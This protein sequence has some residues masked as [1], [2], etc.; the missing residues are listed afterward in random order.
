MVVAAEHAGRGVELPHGHTGSSYFHDLLTRAVASFPEVF[1]G[2]TLPLQP[3]TFKQRYADALASFEAARITSDQRVEIARFVCR[4]ASRELRFVGQGRDVLFDEHMREAADPLPLLR[5]DLPGPGKLVPYLGFEGHIYRGRELLG[6][7]QTL[8]DKH[9][10]TRPAQRALQ[11]VVEHAEREGGLSLQGQRFVLLGAAAELAPTDM[12]LEAGADV[13]WIDLREPSVDRLLD[14]RLG[15]SLS[16]VKGGADLL[17]CPHAVAATVQAFAEAGPVHLCMYAYAPGEAQEWRLTASMNAI[18]RAL[19]RE[20]VA[21]ISMLVS[22]TTPSPVSPDDV[23]VAEAR[24]QN[25]T[26][27]RRTLERTGQLSSGFVAQDSVHVARAVVPVQGVSYQAA[28][29]IGKIL[30]AECYATYGNRFDV[31]AAAPLTV[32]ANVAPITATRSLAHPLFEAAFL[33]APMFDIL[34][35][36]PHTTR[37]LSGMLTLHDLLNPDAPG[38]ADKARETQPAARA[39]QIFSQQIH[40]G[41][42]AQPYALSGCITVAA[43]NGLKRRPGLALR[44]WR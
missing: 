5:V 2:A 28:Q 38:A 1:S 30:A 14:P 41:V 29:Y 27:W 11:W 23:Q 21:S 32:S 19:P 12:L 6:L 33:G 22:P 36:K 10:M 3:K 15:G 24:R 8:T 4:E 34:I 7:L 18:A 31:E 16:Y 17:A 9:W 42:F 37:V 35:S 13:L 43:L 44:L 25:A 20:C 26:G 39:A 40:G